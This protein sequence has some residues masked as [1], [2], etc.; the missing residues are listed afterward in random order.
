MPDYFVVGKPETFKFFVRAI[1]C[2]HVPLE[3]KSY[4]VRARANRQ[5]TIET[6]AKPTGKAGQYA[7][8]LTLPKAGEWTISIETWTDAPLLPMKAIPP[9]AEPPQPLSQV[10]RGERF[11][12]E[13]GCVSCHINREV[14]SPVLP[15]W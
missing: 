3:A 2:E 5:S 15:A 6:P 11:F 10:A 8:T 12:I 4:A 1:C 7:A 13:K 9:G 14:T